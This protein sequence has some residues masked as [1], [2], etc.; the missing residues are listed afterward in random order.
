[1]SDQVVL[2]LPFALS[3]LDSVLDLVVV[4]FD[5]LEFGLLLLDPERES[6]DLVAS[7]VTLHRLLHLQLVDLV[8]NL[9]PLYHDFIVRFF[10]ARNPALDAADLLHDI[11]SYRVNE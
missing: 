7:V 6:L 5:L 10:L 2:V 8:L 3:E 9:V 11:L 1:M 4:D